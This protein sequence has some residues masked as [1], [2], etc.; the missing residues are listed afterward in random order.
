[1]KKEIA[2]NLNVLKVRQPIGDFFIASIPA[3]ELVEITYSDVRR[4]ASEERDIEKYLGIQRPVNPARI[5]DLKKY[6]EAPD[7]TFPTAVILAVDE[8]CAEYHEL[9][10]GFGCLTLSEYIPEDGVEDDG[11]PI[12]KL[13]KVLDG[14]HRIAA[15]LD[16]NNNWEFEFEEERDFD[17]NVAIFVGADIPDQANIFATVNLAQ[18]KVSKNLVYDLTSLAKTRNPYKTCH[19]IAVILDGQE[20]SPFYKRIK[21]LGTATP[22]RTVEPITQAAFVESLVRFISKDPVSDRN[23]LV[24]GKALSKADKKQ[25]CATPFRNLFIENKELDIAEIIYNFFKAVERKWPNS[26]GAIEEKGNILPKSNSFKAFMQYLKTDICRDLINNEFSEVPDIDYFYESISHVDL[27]ESDFNTKNFS[28]GGSGQSTLLK[29]LRGQ[30]K[31]EDFL[32]E[33]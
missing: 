6:L 4:L 26:W 15:F 17:L 31:R 9:D 30:L 18:T 33:G 16:E 21:R 1:M 5:K 14:Q 13:A 27:L 29:V 32:S 2:L 10:S 20:R 3:K 22:G 19:N 12:S 24:D 8:R 7:S 28:P 25:L 11:I 23:S